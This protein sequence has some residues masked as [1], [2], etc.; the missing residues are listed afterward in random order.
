VDPGLTAGERLCIDIDPEEL[1]V[2][3]ERCER[4]TPDAVV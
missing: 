4:A 3:P 2:A 1:A